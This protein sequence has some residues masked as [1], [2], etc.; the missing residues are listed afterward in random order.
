[1]NGEQK[2]IFPPSGNPGEPECTPWIRAWVA[3]PLWLTV[4]L[5]NM[6]PVAKCSKFSR[7]AGH[8]AWTLPQMTW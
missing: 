8:F 5:G 2:K 3:A 7:E 1:M 6:G 4:V